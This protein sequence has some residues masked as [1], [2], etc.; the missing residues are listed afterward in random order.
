[1]EMVFNIAKSLRDFSAVDR[2]SKSD[3]LNK[4]TT[5]NNDCSYSSVIRDDTSENRVHGIV[6]ER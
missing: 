3:T 6:N 2:V 1:M 4:Q 5:Y